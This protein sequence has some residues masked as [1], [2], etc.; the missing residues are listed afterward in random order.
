MLN[1]EYGWFLLFAVSFLATLILTKIWIKIAI[2]EGHVVKDV[3]KYGNKMI[4]YSGGV[5]VMSGFVF[6]VMIYI[7]IS[8]FYIKRP[9]HLVEMFAILSSLLIISFIGFLDD[10]LGGWR[11]GLR[12]W[13]KP[14]LTLPAALP[15]MAI[16]AGDT[17]MSIPFIG[18][19]DAGFLY[20]LILVPLGIVGASQGYNMLAGLNGFD[21]GI[22]AI[23][24]ST[25]SY[26]AWKTD[27]QW[28]AIFVLCMV[29]A[30]LAFL[31]Y[32][33]YPAKVFSGDTLIYALGA[34]IAAVA[35]VGN[36]ER[37][38]LILFIP[39][40]LELLIKLRVKLRSECFLIPDKNGTIR[41]PE[42]I[43]SLTHVMARFL[44]KFTKNL[45]EYHVVIGFY[46]L[47]LILVIAALNLPR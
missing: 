9:T 19:V 46:V 16:K 13:Q 29:F 47:E 36:M 15:L 28:L 41:P 21:A 31:Y 27:Q 43:G 10:N 2:R 26:V 1:L 42:R 25:L 38:A 6:S 40:F 34:L 11:K 14:L 35:I 39:Y 20:P 23:V 5:A 12:R 30:L 7:G 4:P 24:L 17:A 22:G 18:R 44:S 37:V 32:N 3:N 45:M 8:V 33:W